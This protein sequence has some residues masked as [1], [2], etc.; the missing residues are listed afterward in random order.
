MECDT[1]ENLFHNEHAEKRN[2]LQNDTETNF[3]DV[4]IQKKLQNSRDF[5]DENIGAFRSRA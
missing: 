4:T 5:L 3:M 1:T 2:L